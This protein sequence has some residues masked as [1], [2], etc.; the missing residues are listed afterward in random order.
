M[1][2]FKYITVRRLTFQ[3]STSFL[4]LL[5]NN[6]HVN[7]ETIGDC[8]WKPVCNVNDEFNTIMRVIT[9]LNFQITLL[10]CV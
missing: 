1:K 3:K 10:D 2:T 7:T 5:L 9:L 4:F 8:P 6:L